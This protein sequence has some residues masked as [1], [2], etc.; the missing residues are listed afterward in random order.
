MDRAVIN[1]DVSQLLD[2]ILTDG[3]SEAIY[4]AYKA[5][6]TYDEILRNVSKYGI[7][8]GVDF[9]D[10]KHTAA[11]YWLSGRIADRLQGASI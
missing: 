10:W 1:N 6:P 11:K 9:V 3:I 4:Q 2:E 7:E 5:D 8:Y